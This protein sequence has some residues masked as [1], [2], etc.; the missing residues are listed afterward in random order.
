[1]VKS[2]DSGSD[3][4]HADGQPGQA[5]SHDDHA[6]GGLAT[7]AGFTD[8]VSQPATADLQTDDGPA[9]DRRW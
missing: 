3:Q 7:L 8:L 2:R 1:M 6:W 9:H 4:L 5:R